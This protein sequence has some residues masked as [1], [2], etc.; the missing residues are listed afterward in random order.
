MAHTVLLAVIYLAFI[1]LGLPDGVLGV[2]WPAMRGGFGEPLEA[3]GLITL[4]ITACS[5]VSGFASGAVLQRLGT[6]PVVVISGFL[7]GLA[8]LG[9]AAAPSFLWI[10]LLAVPLGLGAGS[11]DA[12]LNHFV[13]RHYSSRH[14]NW[15]HACWG[16]GASIGPLIMGAALAKNGGWA[17]AY[18]SIASLQL[19]LA[20]V[21]LLTLA[22]WKREPELAQG[23]EPDG[24]AGP[25]SG[26]API[27]AG[28]LAPSLYLMYATVEVGTGLWAASILVE[29]RGLTPRDAAWWVSC[30]YAAIM[31]GRFALG[32]IAVRLGNRRL[33]HGGLA[34]ALIGAALFAIP[35]LPSALTLAGL[36]LLGLGAAPVYPSLM[37]ETTRRFE[38]TLARRVVGRQVAFASLGAATGPAA[39]GLLGAHWGSNAIM[40]MLV[41]VLLMLWLLVW[42]LDQVS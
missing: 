27:W 25:R 33:V 29:Q 12:G 42:R 40:P 11:V 30:F 41:L 14:M 21:F 34:L 9:F 32:L 2:A 15:L 16:V 6:G 26:P 18:R 20:V 39:L 31:S 23:L 1:S 5:A 37:H 19:M 36:V 13:A 22:L 17:D 24:S 28:W 35:G 10:L 7:T 38:A 8:L 3:A 4:V